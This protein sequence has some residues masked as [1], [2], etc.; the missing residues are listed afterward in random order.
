MHELRAPLA[1]KTNKT[2]KLGSNEEK[3]KPSSLR[4]GKY[5]KTEINKNTKNSTHYS[6]M[7]QTLETL[8]NLKPDE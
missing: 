4:K 6:R 3:Y 8:F 5:T 1:P 2:K 7:A